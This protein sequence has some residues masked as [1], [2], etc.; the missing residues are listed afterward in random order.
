MAQRWG[1]NK[2]EGQEIVGYVRAILASKES[3]L[4]QVRDE[5]GPYISL[6][7]KYPIRD[8]LGYISNEPE[9]T[10][11][12]L[13]AS[14]FNKEMCGEYGYKNVRRA[15]KKAGILETYGSGDNKKIRIDGKRMELVELIMENGQESINDQVYTWA[16]KR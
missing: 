4:I 8:A 2:D 16:M 15:L 12:L 9:R 6:E 10:V 11:Y 1:K 5:Q 13:I 7:S 3:Q 14:Q